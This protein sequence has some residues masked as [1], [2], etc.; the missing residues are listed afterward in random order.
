MRGERFVHLV[1]CNIILCVHNG[2][3]V[4]AWLA[5]H[6]V[7]NVGHVNVVVLMEHAAR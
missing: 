7:C 3:C 1:H 6:V 4:R 2:L 5:V